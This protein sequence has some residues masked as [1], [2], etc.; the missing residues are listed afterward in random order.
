MSR[1]YHTQPKAHRA[2]VTE[3]DTIKPDLDDAIITRGYQECRFDITLEGEDIQELG[4]RLLFYNQRLKVWFTGACYS[5]NSAGQHSIT[6][7]TRGGTVFLWLSSFK[8]TTFN[9]SA[10]YCLS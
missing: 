7:I 2:E 10:D 5:L 9:F 6:A 8:G 1:I 3:I 4:L